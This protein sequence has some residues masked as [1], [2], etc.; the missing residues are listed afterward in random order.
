MLETIRE[1][2]NNRYVDA[3]LF[4]VGTIV[5]LLLLDCCDGRSGGRGCRN[6]GE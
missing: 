1:I 5:F 4:I 2:L 6:D 3:A